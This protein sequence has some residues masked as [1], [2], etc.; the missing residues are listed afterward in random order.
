MTK[1]KTKNPDTLIMMHAHN[2]WSRLYTYVMEAVQELG[3]PVCH[4]E[5]ANHWD[6]SPDE[7]WI[8]PHGTRNKIYDRAYANREADWKQLEQENAP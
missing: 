5:Y 6:G 3:I 7:E 1:W 8:V 4:R 2:Q